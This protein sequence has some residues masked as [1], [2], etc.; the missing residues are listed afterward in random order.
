MI[1][2]A[3]IL[4][5]FLAYSFSLVH[6]LVPH[7][8]H[9]EKVAHTHHEHHSDSNRNDDSDN[10]TDHDNN[11]LRDIFAE[12]AHGSAS[13]FFIHAQ[14]SEQKT[15]VSYAFEF[16]FAYAYSLTPSDKQPPG[17]VCIDQQEL[18]DYNV[19]SISL[20]RAPPAIV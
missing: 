2:R 8:H 12:F 9:E 1:K 10:D 17:F 19:S 18:Y 13:N 11:Q 14:T 4:L 16:V 5:T 6:S 20:L 3:T 7:H 15:K